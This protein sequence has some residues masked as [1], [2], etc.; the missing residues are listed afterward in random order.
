M[1]CSE[2]DTPKEVKLKGYHAYWNIEKG[3]PGVAI[4]SKIK[5][6]KVE[7]DLP[8]Q[9]KNVK[10]LITAEFEDFFL[11]STY[12]VN[13]GRGLKT[14]DKRL[15]WNKVFD[16]HVQKLDKKKPVIIAG[17]MNVAHEEIDLANPKSNHKSAGF[18]PQERE[19]MTTLLSYG[20]VDSYRHFYPD[21]K[22]AYTFWSYMGN[23]R[24]KNVGWRLDYF[25]VSERLMKQVKDCVIRSSIKGSD[26]CPIVLYLDL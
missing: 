14:L 11:V 8:G 5:P 16:D 12:V 17:D 7:N 9:F 4:L 25:I 3:M 26:H 2:A 19:G 6:L 10:R 23:A 18:S 13:A 1:K 20:F 22:G 24:A 15:E 21:K